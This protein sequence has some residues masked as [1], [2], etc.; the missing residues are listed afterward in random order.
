MDPT[1]L[2]L[3]TTLRHSVDLDSETGLEMLIGGATLLFMA[4]RNIKMFVITVALAGYG[5]MTALNSQTGGD[6]L[7]TMMSL[8][9]IFD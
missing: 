3:L 6:V 4:V 8:H 7:R 5:A 2:T 1:V 9:R